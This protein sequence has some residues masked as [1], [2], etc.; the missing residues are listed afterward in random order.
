MTSNLGAAYLSDM[1][2]GPV[3]SQTKELVMGTI[4]G[5]FPPEFINRIDEIIIFVSIRFHEF[6][7]FFSAGVLT[8]LFLLA[9]PLVEK[10]KEDRGNPTKGGPRSFG[11]EED[12]P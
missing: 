3:K 8:R 7:I 5:H 9:C 6:R 1:G 11:R 12:V 4:R 2:E 10:R